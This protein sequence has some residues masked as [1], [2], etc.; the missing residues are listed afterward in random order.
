MNHHYKLSPNSAELAVVQSYIFDSSRFIWLESTI[1]HANS[2]KIL[3]SKTLLTVVVFKITQWWCVILKFFF[4]L[5]LET[6]LSMKIVMRLGVWL[7]KCIVVS[8]V[9]YL[10]GCLPSTK[11]TCQWLHMCVVVLMLFVCLNCTLCNLFFVFL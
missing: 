7:V 10:I 3:H 9:A 11:R 6:S 8:K 5:M 2:S 1:S 4:F